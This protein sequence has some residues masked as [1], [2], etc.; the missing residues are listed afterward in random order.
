MGS[1]G[2]QCLA[3]SRRYT[4]SVSLNEQVLGEHQETV[5]GAREGFFMKE[6]GNG[7]PERRCEVIGYLQN[8]KF[9]VSGCVFIEHVVLIQQGSEHSSHTISSTL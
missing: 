6:E 4:L 1:P 2:A 9:G 8:K 3:L 5:R 7:V